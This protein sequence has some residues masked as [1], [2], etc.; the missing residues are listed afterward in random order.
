M[1]DIGADTLQHLLQ[2]GSTLALLDV[3]EHGE[4]NRAHI[5][6]A[7]A[8]PRRLI[9]HRIRQ[10]VPGRQTQIVLCDDTGLR[11][12]LAA[13]TLERLGYARVAVLDGGL[14][15]WASDERPTE[16]GMNVPSK[17][18]GEKVEIQQHV[19]S[20]DARELAAR[21]ARGD[22]LTILDTRTPDEYARFCIPGGR[23]VPNGELAYRIGEIQRERPT[24][25]IVVNCA[26]RTRG[27]IGTRTLQRM[28]LQNVVGLKNGTSGWVLAGQ[29]LEAGARRLELPEPS[30]ETRA[31]AEAYAR[32][33]MAEDGVRTVA[34]EQLTELQARDDGRSL[35]CIDVR[36]QA[37][38][39]QGHIPGFWWFPGGQVVQR[40]DDA[41]AV[42]NG[43]VV[44]TCD[45][46]ARAGVAAS[47]LRQLGF[48]NV[49][50]LDGGAAAWA[51]SGRALE[52]GASEQLPAGLPE[53]QARVRPMDPRALA[54]LLKTPGPPIVLHVGTS[55][56]FAAGHVL[57]S[58]WLPRGWLEPRLDALI[59]DWTEPIVVTSVDGV[60]A[61]LAAATLLDL[62][63]HDVAV[64]AGGTRAWAAARLPVERGLTGVMDPPDD[65]VPAGTDRGHAD[66]VEYLRWEEALGKKYAPS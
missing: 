58:H 22:D 42:R 28:G 44:L 38:Y 51:A 4:Y 26:G 3:R 18:F 52:S 64:L 32:R 63:Y 1:L 17:E 59:P 6:G 13:K 23:S 45:G 9:E 48:P 19:P 12:R 60:D 56:E 7:S 43:T 53:A 2:T 29:Q 55:R 31:Q 10:L 50:V 49:S 61:T 36:T 8:L 27:I 24:A 66:M 33:I 57:G 30:P 41:V 62:G 5:P 39:E 16:W 65:I 21:I 15:G 37:E 14:N 40:S 46:I 47:W 34:P 54:G 11:S 35:Y 20:I 25:Q